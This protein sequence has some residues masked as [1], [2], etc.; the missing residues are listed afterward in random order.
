MKITPGTKRFFINELALQGM[1]EAS[2]YAELRPKVAEQVKPWVFTKNAPGGRIAKPLAEQYVEL[3]HEISRV[4]AAIEREGS[5]LPSPK[6]QPDAPKPDETPKPPRAKGKIDRDEE[7]R[8]FV[9]EWKRLRR[10]I[11]ETAERNGTLPIDSLDTMRPIEAAKQLIESGISAKTLVYAMVLHWPKA[12][13]EMANVPDA[14]FIDESESL[15]EGFHKLAGYVMK[16]CRASRGQGFGVMLIGPA[17]TGKSRIAKQAASLIKTE[18]HPNG[19]PYGEA[20][21]TP[22]ATRGDLL[23]RHTINGFIASD[24]VEI[25]SGG[26]VFN[27]EEI[28]AADPSMLLVVNNAI[29]GDE[30]HNSANGQVYKKHPD[31]IAVGT[32]NT[33][34]LGSDSKYTGREKL[35]LATIDRF[36]MCRVLVSLDEALAESLMYG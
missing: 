20:P 34:G 23:G 2:V 35:D 32:A 24:F 9:A 6:P 5:G 18:A 10:W 28:D 8:F 15:G 16:L 36:R 26:G 29:A 12:S 13:R 3:R 30:L 11:A 21:L 31:F 22:G 25:Y 1:T 4:F 14:D 19:L 7:K 33:F 27:F 17:G